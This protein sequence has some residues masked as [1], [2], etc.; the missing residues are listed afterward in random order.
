LNEENRLPFLPSGKEEVVKLALI[1]GGSVVGFL[2]TVG[3]SYY[4]GKNAG[5]RMAGEDP[6]ILK[7]RI[8]ELKAAKKAA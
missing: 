1:I 7:A 2:A 6:A 8:K 5:I 4:L 3:V